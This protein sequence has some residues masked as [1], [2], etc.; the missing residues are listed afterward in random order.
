[1]IRKN[2]ISSSI[3]I[4]FVMIS[5]FISTP[6]FTYSWSANQAEAAQVQE[7]PRKSTSQL[8]AQ[9]NP[10]LIISDELFLYSPEFDTVEEIQAFLD[11]QPGTL[12]TYTEN[13]DGV[14]KTAAQIIFEA[15][16]QPT[17]V[18]YGLNPQVLLVLLELGG[19][20]ISDPHPSRRSVDNSMG[21]E[22]SIHR[23]L[24]AQLI[25]ATLELKLT[26]S[27][28]QGLQLEPQIAT[29]SNTADAAEGN[30]ASIAVG[31]FLEQYHGRQNDQGE[32][33]S[34][35]PEIYESLFG[36]LPRQDSVL[37]TDFT[38]AD[39]TWPSTGYIGWLFSNSHSGIDV[40]TK[41]NDC[42]NAG[43][44]R[45]N[46]VY[47]AYAGRVVLVLPDPRG[48][49]QA[50]VIYH[51]EINLYTRYFHMADEYTG[52]SFVNVVVNQEVNTS[53]RLGFQGNRRWYTNANESIC[54]HLHFTM[55]IN[56]SSTGAIDPSP[57]YGIQLNAEAPNSVG[58]MYYKEYNASN[59]P[60]QPTFTSG[61]ALGPNAIR[62]Q[63]TTSSDPDN[64]RIYNRTNGL[65][66]TFGGG[67]RWAYLYDLQCNKDYEFELWAVKSGRESVHTSRTVRSG[68][69][70]GT[71]ARITNV[72]FTP[73]SLRSGERLEVRVTVENIGS[74]VLRSQSPAPYFEYQEGQSAHSLGYSDQQGRFRVGIGC[75]GATACND[76]PYRWG[77][78]RDLNPGESTT[79]V[80]YIRLNSVRNISYFAGLVEELVK[81]HQQEQS[82]TAIV[83]NPA[84][85][86]C[87]D[88]YEPNENWYQSRNIAVGQTVQAPI[89][90]TNDRDWFYVTAPGSGRLVLDVWNIPAGRDYDV[91][92]YHGPSGYV[93]GSY[94][95]SNSSE[96][97]EFQVIGGQEYDAKVYSYS[98]YSTTSPYSLRFQYYATSQAT[99][100]P[101]ASSEQDAAALRQSR[102]DI[103]LHDQK[104]PAAPNGAEYVGLLWPESAETTEYFGQF[105][106]VY[107]YHEGVTP[108]PGQ[109][110]GIEC[111]LQWGQVETWGGDWINATGALMNYGWDSD[112]YDGYYAHFAP[113]AGMYEYTAVCDIDG[114]W[115]WSDN[116]SGNGRL[117]V[118]PRYTT[119]V[120]SQPDIA[121]TVSP[122]TG[123]YSGNTSFTAVPNSGYEFERWRI[124]KNDTVSYWHINPLTIDIDMDDIILEAIFRPVG[125]GIYGRVNYQG[126]AQSDVAISLQF[127]NGSTFTTIATTTTDWNGNYSF[128]GLPSLGSGQLYYV[129]FF[130]DTD[131]PDYLYDW[132]GNHI[133]EY[134]AGSNV[135]GGDFDIADIDLGGP[136]TLD[137]SFFPVEFSW[138]SRSI[139]SEEQYAV[140]I[141][142]GNSVLHWSPLQIQGSNYLMNALPHEIRAS[143]DLDWDVVIVSSQGMGR[144][145]DLNQVHF[146]EGS[147]NLTGHILYQGH[148]DPGV[149]VGLYFYDGAEWQVVDWTATNNEGVYQFSRLLDLQAGQYYAPFY[150]NFD[151]SEK[152]NRIWYGDC[153]ATPEYDPNAFNSACDIET[154]DVFLEGPYVQPETFPVRFNWST[155]SA[156]Y[157]EA[158]ELRVYDFEAGKMFVGPQV[159]NAQEYTL[160]AL[161]T[162][163]TSQDYFWE[164][165]TYSPMGRAVSYL[166]NYVNAPHKVYLPLVVRNFNGTTAQ[167]VA[168]SDPTELSIQS[169]ALSRDLLPVPRPSRYV[170]Q[171]S[172]LRAIDSMPPFHFTPFMDDYSQRNR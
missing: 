121:G 172:L 41:K 56:S 86:G 81:W 142:D 11:Q 135:H 26:F 15:T 19:K 147:G 119:L 159:N 25:W 61:V 115:I 117:I 50:V 118:Y 124:N 94:A 140:E 53:T 27:H 107:V 69:C 66:H 98:G 136:N 30:P 59:P 33:N 39:F 79:V 12:A 37:G 71:A 137:N 2:T 36:V 168:K 47:P 143:Q 156:L 145:W 167:I 102:L 148:P 7:A 100:E 144:S 46:P 17:E 166:I 54:V 150:V 8:Q 52:E 62:L 125:T 10:N 74:T 18:E 104:S 28:Y 32:A 24:S 21:F 9:I 97:Y 171:P 13:V 122:G 108:A 3:L 91:E 60:P 149:Y 139:Y 112:V 93:G 151:N 153:Y 68:A 38:L 58:W 73:Q 64:F 87:S 70:P 134:Y 157:T 161:P 141:Y 169:V 133:S 78:G 85:T 152:P 129:Q 80:G 67:D 22:D 34:A 130:N 163:F 40:W 126:W 99:T 170:V 113:S 128:V 103:A 57:Y 14:E 162:G 120:F 138:A 116:P 111:H 123:E 6:K 77:L 105:V 146:A 154:E 20:L 88:L 83:V 90:D 16:S 45:G 158:Y 160:T 101:Q 165:W 164:I 75:D 44:A 31:E 49:K 63:W 48:V 51:P 43:N 23:G 131:N 89:C 127:Y 1:M 96:R 29:P 82:R 55:S 110:A 76:Y 42:T 84:S 132:R 5:L 92:L 4:F 106:G 109:G 72:Q 114:E 35:F 155:R 95:G 65:T